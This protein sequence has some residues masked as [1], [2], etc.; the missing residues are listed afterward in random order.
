[1]Q[2]AARLGG[3]AVLFDT[4]SLKRGEDGRKLTGK[5]IVFSQAKE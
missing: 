1:M 5:V 2:E 4:E 3:Q